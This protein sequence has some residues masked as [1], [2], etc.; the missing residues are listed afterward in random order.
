[1]DLQEFQ[2]LSYAIF[3]PSPAAFLRIVGQA[4]IV[5][6]DMG[7]T[8]MNELLAMA[9]EVV[10]ALGIYTI[11]LFAVLIIRNALTSRVPHP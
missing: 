7:R 10:A 6:S 5:G 1:M 11:G 9:F 8:T 4:S 2:L 3:R